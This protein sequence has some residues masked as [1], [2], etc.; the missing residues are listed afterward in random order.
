MPGCLDGGLDVDVHNRSDQAADIGVSI[1]QNGVELYN[2]TQNVGSKEIV[3][4]WNGLDLEGDSYQLRV[5]T[6]DVTMS[7]DFTPYTGLYIWYN[8]TG[9]TAT[10]SK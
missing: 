6:E 8:G 1:S 4:Y 10:G 5:W 2:R 9:F 7:R 3:R